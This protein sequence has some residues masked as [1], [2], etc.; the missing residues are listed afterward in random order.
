MAVG[1]AS[2]AVGGAVPEPPEAPPLAGGVEARTRGAEGADVTVRLERLAARDWTLGPL[3]IR[4]FARLVVE[5]GSVTVQRA[6]VAGPGSALTPPASAHPGAR[7]PVIALLRRLAEG[8]AGRPLVDFRIRGFSFAVLRGGER[9]LAL[10]AREAHVEPDHEG[11]ELRDLR[12]D[13]RSGQRLEARWVRLRWDP[14]QLELRGPWRICE[15]AA[16]VDHAGRARLAFEPASG[17]LVRSPGA[18]DD[19]ATSR[20]AGQHEP[21]GGR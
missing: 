5:G 13:T 20:E 18:P 4:P 14:E 15:D 1:P 12:G 8:L 19:A 2:P 16:C 17:R 21:R 9:V 10:E 6:E 7:E 11:L 3:A